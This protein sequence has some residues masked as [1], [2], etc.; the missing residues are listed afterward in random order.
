VCVRESEDK[1][2]G[3]G[4]GSRVVA[5]VKRCVCHTEIKR[6]VCQKNSHLFLTDSP[7]CQ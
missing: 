2:V 6:L 5:H 4:G 1:C 3:G 7:A